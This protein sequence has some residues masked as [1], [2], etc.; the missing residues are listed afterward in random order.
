MKYSQPEKEKSRE[1]IWEHAISSLTHKRNQSTVINPEIMNELTLKA[2]TYLKDIYEDENLTFNQLSYNH[3]WEIFHNSVYQ[4]RKASEL[5]VVFFCGPEPINDLKHLLSRGVRPENIWGFELDPNNYKNA[6]EE[7]LREEIYIN[8]YQGN[9][10]EFIKANPQK[11]DI[12]YLD[13][14]NS[15][16]S[17]KKNPLL[18]INS[19]FDSTIISDLTIIIINS[20]YPEVEKENIEFLKNYFEYKKWI[21]RSLLDNNQGNKFRESFISHS[22]YDSD[23]TKVI[24]SKFEESYSEFSS[25]IFDLFSN[26]ISPLNRITKL[27][28]LY[29]K[30]FNNKKLEEAIEAFKK[31][32]MCDV[33]NSCGGSLEFDTD[34]YGYW[35]FIEN[36]IKDKSTLATFFNT[37]TENGKFTPFKLVQFYSL[38][39]TIEAA[40]TDAFS[41]EIY[42][43][44]KKIQKNTIE[45]KIGNP[46]SC[47]FCDLPMKQLWYSL[48]IGK[49]GYPCHINYNNHR[50]YSYT[51]KTRKMCLDMYTID[52][53][54]SLYDYIPSFEFI[55]DFFSDN[56]RQLIIRSY[57]D[58]IYKTQFNYND[59]FFQWGRSI[60]QP[61]TSCPNPC[62]AQG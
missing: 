34:N 10:N 31:L 47:L 11:F 9:I 55:P 3:D 36:T 60:K 50:R 13:F 43:I 19:L 16:I 39:Y 38:M 5:K 29:K 28:S 1:L 59:S 48:L 17:P 18:L 4:N 23:L 56:H 46:H 15:L 41:D 42:D 44:V 30:L 53:C 6:K 61:L 40:Y 8:L 45:N 52:K 25:S 35:T 14:T 20:C 62:F 12:V 26:V 58:K 32:D 49:Y 54:R 51:A 7:L 33:E 2:K 37:K 27:P 57:I 21:H 22:I 24:E